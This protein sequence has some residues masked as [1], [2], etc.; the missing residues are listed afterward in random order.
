MVK[1]VG[2]VSFNNVP[3]NNNS[4][5]TQNNNNIVIDFSNQ[6]DGVKTIKIESGMTLSELAVQYNTTVEDILIANGRIEENQYID[7]E[8][9]NTR[10]FSIKAG[11]TL[12]IPV[13]TAPF[14][15]QME[16]QHNKRVDIENKELQEKGITT[17][18]DKAKHF[19]QKDLDAGHL[20]FVPPKKFLGI[21]WGGNY[22]KYTPYE[23]YAETYGELKDRYNLPDGILSQRNYI[24]GGG[25]YDNAKI[26]HT[27]KIP[28]SFLEKG[29]E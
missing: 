7:P 14:E 20:E 23:Y 17:P 22:Y 19:I 27:V 26:D 25:N 1:E 4:G 29:L 21:E 6:T 8:K 9:D 16:R 3:Q 24:P 15:L 28:K 13:N 11:E 18:E 12:K 10:L 5:N 2:G